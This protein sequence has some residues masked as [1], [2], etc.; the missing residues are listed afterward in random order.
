VSA[1]DRGSAT[2]WVAALVVVVVTGTVLVVGGVTAT[3]TRHAAQLA[4]D[5]AAL[6]GAGRI[7]VAPVD[8][9]CRA[10][11]ASAEANHASVVR[12]TVALTGV[13]SG[14]VRV[15]VRRHARFAG[16]DLDG[17]ARARAARVAPDL[18]AVPS[19]G[20]G[21]PAVWQHDPGGTAGVGR[22]RGIRTALGEPPR[23]S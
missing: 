2:V 13:R 21:R 9:V 11:R 6:A 17:R 15:E 14:E 5:L 7:G 19:L 8:D 23:R 22:P 10:A 3:A 4:A 20:A 16:I 12:C 18:S 1:R